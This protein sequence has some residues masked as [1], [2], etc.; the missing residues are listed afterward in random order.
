MSKIETIQS[1][2]ITLQEIVEKEYVFDI[3]IYQRLYVWKGEQVK[4]LLDDL[5][6]A[7]K[8]DKDIFYLG[9]VLVVENEE[10]KNFTEFD[11]IDGQQRFTTLWMMSIVFKN[12]LSAFTSLKLDKASHHRVNFSIRMDIKDFFESY[13]VDKEAIKGSTPN[14]IN[15]FGVME[16]FMR[17]LPEEKLTEFSTFLFEKVQLLFTSVPQ[18]TDLNKLFEIINNRGVQLQHHEILKAQ[19]LKLLPSDE[20]MKYSYLWDACS[21]MDNYVEKNISDIANIKIASLF[22]NENSTNGSENLSNAKKV[23]KKITV[24]EEDDFKSLSLIEILSSSDKE[25]EENNEQ[26]KDEEYES[27]NKVRS[28]ITFSMLLQ[29]T[30]RI[31]LLRYNEGTE[32][33]IPKILDK[34]LLSIFSASYL[35]DVL[36]EDEDAAADDVRA[37]I[38][39]LWEVRYVFDKHVIK[40][41]ETEDGEIH[42][43]NK[44]YKSQS[45]GYYTLT[46]R[47]PDSN[48]GCSLLQSMLYHSQ[49]LTTHYW[50]TPYLNYLLKNKGKN[51]YEYLRYLDNNLLS[52][53]QDDSLINRTH[54]FLVEPYYKTKIDYAILQEPEGVSFAHYWFYK[55]EFILWF[56]LK[57]TKDI[58]WKDFRFTAKNSVEH[59]SPQTPKKED[60]NIVTENILDTFGNLSLVSR[61]INSEYSNLPYNEKRQRFANKNANDVD[62][63]KMDLIYSSKNWNDDKAQEHQEEMLN[64]MDKYFKQE[65]DFE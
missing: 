57:D 10:K 21:Y 47:K 3:P 20:R 31:H 65:I 6:N 11:L 30:L 19:L 55:L 50:L 49:Q 52:G 34:E 63:L 41:V 59:I 44:L 37:F 28:I 25:I 2:L 62:S 9:G 45:K 18:R 43:I 1:D 38:E 54:Q 7:Y 35:D 33:D 46:R 22:E 4:I 51:S 24:L 32:Y 15:A 17:T 23:L 14:I 53:N 58:R 5:Y 60:T 26:S 61:S 40:W 36:P 13:M 12:K 27:D 8:E 56:L 39:L 48:D 29:H 42:L 16:S 64:Y